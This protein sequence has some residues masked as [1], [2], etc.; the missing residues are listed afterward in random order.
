MVDPLDLEPAK[1][2]NQDR[3]TVGVSFVSPHRSVDS[4][5]ERSGRASC[6]FR[7][8]SDVDRDQ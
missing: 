1:D 3:G 5:G 7:G 2:P 6:A 4:D 8:E